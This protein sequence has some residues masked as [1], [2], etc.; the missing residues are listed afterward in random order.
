MDLIQRAW[1]REGLLGWA[2][3]LLLLPWSWLM[4]LALA[5]HRRRR[6]AQPT[7]DRDVPVVIVGNLTVGGTG[8]TPLTAWIARDLRR[9]GRRPA[10]VSRGYR[11]RRDRDPA[12]VSDGRRVRLNAAAAGDEPVML[13]RQL[14][15]VP[16]VV[17]RD[18][19]AGA[20]LAVER[21][22]ADV[23]ILDDGFQVRARFPGAL[24]VLVVHGRDG[25]GAGLFPA[26]PLREP[27]EATADADLV[28]MTHGRV[29]PLPVRRPVFRCDH[30]TI[31]RGVRGR[32]VV[33][34]SGIGDP[35]SFEA[36]LRR[37]A[38]AR[39]VISCRVPDHHRWTRAE[40]VYARALAR[41]E[42]AVLATTAKDAV[43]LPGAVR[44]AQLELVFARGDD[45]RL[46]ARLRAHLR[47]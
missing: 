36:G 4:R 24:R 29:T 5:V 11:G 44:V 19:V 33:A 34:M 46:R 9:A 17:G 21:C 27:T 38:G 25:V 41:R 47:R 43:R 13:A 39:R 14:P 23:L 2:G 22:G 31:L 8:K 15:G 35:A 1:R 18:R 32:T 37:D 16:V 3:F 28:V 10:V 12:V 42:R 40:Y 6:A 45:R 7:F 20:S 30:R 26:G